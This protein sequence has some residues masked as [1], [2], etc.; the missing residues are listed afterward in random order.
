MQKKKNSQ[1]VKKCVYSKGE[2]MWY[3]KWQLRNCDGT[4]G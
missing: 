2:K 4:M 3:Q 1:A